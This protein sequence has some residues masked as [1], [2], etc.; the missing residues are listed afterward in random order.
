M[1]RSIIT[2]LAM[3]ILTSCGMEVQYVEEAKEDPVPPVVI[4]EPEPAPVIIICED[5]SEQVL[6]E[7]YYDFNIVS[8]IDPC[9]PSHTDKNDIIFLD[10][11]S[12]RYSEFAETGI[13]KLKANG[14]YVTEDGQRARYRTYFEEIFISCALT[15]QL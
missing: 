12:G 6:P 15:P 1:K 7:G 5:G 8:C 13:I 2:L 3:A 9:G 10:D 11:E 4:V 14:L